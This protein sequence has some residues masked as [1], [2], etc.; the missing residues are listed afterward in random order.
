MEPAAQGLRERLQAITFSDPDYPVVSNVTAAPV[1]SGA[2]ARDLLVKQ[3]TSP[4]RWARS[5]AAMVEA[6]ADRFLELGPGSVLA[7]LNRRNAKGLACSSLGEPAD[8]EA[9]G[10]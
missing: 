3:L 8:I 6:G 10:A 4:V 7:G 9:I 1:S 2:A 5:V